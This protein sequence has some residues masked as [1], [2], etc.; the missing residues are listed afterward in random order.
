MPM[1][2]R[3]PESQINHWANRYTERQREINRAR[4][5]YLINLKDEVQ[6]RGHLTKNELYEIARWKSPQTRRP[7][8]R[9]YRCLHR[10]DHTNGIHSHR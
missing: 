8:F 1:N 4:E 5:E 6:E 7:H 2:L 10:R 9:E 3:F